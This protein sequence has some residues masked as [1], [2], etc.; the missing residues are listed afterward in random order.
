M[1]YLLKR[2]IQNRDFGLQILIIKILK[3]DVAQ[4]EDN[5]K[6]V[7]K[8]LQN[9]SLLAF[10]FPNYRKSSKSLKCFDQEDSK[11]QRSSSPEPEL[12][13]PNTTVDAFLNLF[14]G[15][16]FGD[17]RKQIELAIDKTLIP[18]ESEAKK[19]QSR[20]NAKKQNRLQ[21]LEEQSEELKV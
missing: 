15:E 9:E 11:N 8:L 16:R 19:Q 14:F 4:S 5:R 10:F 3:Y 1:A 7:A 2:L 20:L 13:G 21:R 17:E 6:Y 18:V 12:L